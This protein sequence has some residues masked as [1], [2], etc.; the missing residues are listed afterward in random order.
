MAS[1]RCPARIRRSASTRF[2][3]PM[4]GDMY[5][6]QVFERRKKAL[7]HAPSRLCSLRPIMSQ[8]A[9]ILRTEHLSRIPDGR[10]VVEEISLTVAQAK[11]LAIALQTLALNINFASTFSA[12]RPQRATA[13]LADA[14]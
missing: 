13:G 2:F 11:V 9:P 10:P 8:S 6:W 5:N 14:S 4:E 12:S 3:C 1:E 7:G